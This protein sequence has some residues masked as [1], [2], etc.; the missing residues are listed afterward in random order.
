[1]RNNSQVCMV[2]KPDERNFLQ[3]LP[4]PLPWPWFLV[5]RMLT[6]DLFAIA[7]VLVFC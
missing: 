1:M 4:R 2:I 5:T 7:N 3:G 6:R